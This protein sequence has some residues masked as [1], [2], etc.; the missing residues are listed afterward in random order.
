M[1]PA[2]RLLETGARAGDW[3]MGCD[4][5]LLAAAAA[6]TIP[7]TLRF[8]GWSPPA[9]SLGAHQ[10]EPDPAA[11]AELGAR[12][13]TWV[14]RPTGGRAVWH[15]PAEAELTY[16]VVIP[17]G[18]PR[19]T[20]GLTASY[21]LIHQ[22]LAAGFA[23]LGIDAELA[24]PASRR[25]TSPARASSGP[26]SRRACFAAAVPGELTVR[27]RKLVG[28]AQRRVRGALLQHGSIP[29]TGDQA[30]LAAAWPN[31]LSPSGVATVEW[32]AGRRYSS[33]TVTAAMAAGF[34]A[35]LGVA[36]EPGPPPPGPLDL[37]RARTIC[38]ASP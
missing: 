34:A 33:A 25:A 10:P 32:A 24:A 16:S 36:F 37:A 4:T 6:G 9:V 30:V 3:N 18:T 23:R 2:W 35:T 21:R 19:F 17:A 22:A 14:R 8:Y 28:S 12:G 7:P 29:L 38:S 27:G 1:T 13:V 20:G 31:C 15:G 11:V 26:H 5:A